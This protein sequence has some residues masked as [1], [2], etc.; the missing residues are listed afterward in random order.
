MYQVLLYCWRRLV[1]WQAFHVRK[2]HCSKPACA[3]MYVS[4]YISFTLI[5]SKILKTWKRVKM[6]RFWEFSE[7]RIE[8]L[9]ES[10]YTNYPLHR[11]K[12]DQPKFFFKTFRFSMMIALSLANFWWGPLSKSCRSR[13]KESQQS[14]ITCKQ[15][16]PARTISKIEKRRE[17]VRAL[18]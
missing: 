16:E 2:L 5:L 17:F 13:K 9:I 14:E 6:G 12:F 10:N 8:N 18:C 11:I 7:N 3:I 4:T 1:V 15:S